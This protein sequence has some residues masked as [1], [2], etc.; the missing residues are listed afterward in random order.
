VSTIASIEAE[1]ETSESAPAPMAALSRDRLLAL[2][3]QVLEHWLLAH[4]K[5][6]TAARREGFRLLALHRQAAQGAPSFNACRETCREI[7]Y[8]FNLAATAEDAEQRW[9]HLVT[10][11]RLVQHLTL[12][13][14]GKLQSAQLGE[15]CCSSRALREADG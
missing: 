6:P 4:G 3:E 7:A 13:V 2:A 12:F 15:F 11:R 8:R 5:T 1:L 14:S 10:L 9:Q